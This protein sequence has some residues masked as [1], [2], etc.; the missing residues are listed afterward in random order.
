MLNVTGLSKSFGGLRAVNRVSMF[1]G[2]REIVG[3]IGPNGAGKTTLF[4]LITGTYLPDEG[5]IEFANTNVTRFGPDKRCRM[6]VSRTFQIVRIFPE[7]S[8]LQNV[9]VGRIY[10]RAALNVL[11]PRDAKVA[12]NEAR[13][14]LARVGLA[15]HAATHAQHLTLMDRKRLEL[16]RALAAGPR[17]LLLDE[18]L[19]GLNPSEVNTALDLIRG[20]RESG[21]SIIMVEHLVSALFSI[22]DRVVCL[23][24]GEK[25]AED[26]PAA[27]AANPAVVAA[28]LGDAPH[29]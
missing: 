8:A 17:L 14:A 15:Q 11:S 7:L 28:Y 13:Q 27:I 25:I 5:R 23:A 22:V 16:A 3:L 18:F 24:A 29:A 4:N 10:G 12:A 2:E 26:L 21:V 19:A 6:G 1:V 9:C 20:I